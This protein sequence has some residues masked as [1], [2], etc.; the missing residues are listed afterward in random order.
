MSE[1]KVK[2]FFSLRTSYYFIIESIDPLY[3][4]NNVVVYKALLI[5]KMCGKVV[6]KIFIVNVISMHLS[7]T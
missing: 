2:Y 5:K 1:V 7:A 6:Y 4:V 3:F